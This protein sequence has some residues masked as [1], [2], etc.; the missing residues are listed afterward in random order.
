MS[1]C[2]FGVLLSLRKSGG[3]T[4]MGA[5]Q[6]PSMLNLARVLMNQFGTSLFERY[7]SPEDWERGCG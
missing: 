3:D 1:L 7:N 5:H 6:S 2:L 4:G